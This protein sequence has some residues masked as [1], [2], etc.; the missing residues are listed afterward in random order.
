MKNEV[1]TIV[2]VKEAIEREFEDY[3][4]EQIAKGAEEVFCNAFRINAWSSIYDFLDSNE[5]SDETKIALYEKCNGHILSVL[6]DEYV[7]T[8][9]CD[10]AQYSD[11]KELVN[12]FLNDEE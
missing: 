8:E 3:K 12:N 2:T 4:A 9:Y 10:I 1:T 5:L 7:Y 6:V 11:L